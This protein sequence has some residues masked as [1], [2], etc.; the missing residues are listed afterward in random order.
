MPEDKSVTVIG[1]VIPLASLKDA[2]SSIEYWYFVI[3]EGTP[4]DE[5]WN[6]MFN[7]D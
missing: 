2:P 6:A 7:D 3:C 4:P 5:S 1:L